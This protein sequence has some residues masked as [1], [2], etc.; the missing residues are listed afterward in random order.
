MFLKVSNLILIDIDF[1]GVVIL[2]NNSIL[3]RFCHKSK[4]INYFSIFDVVIS[5]LYF[6]SAKNLKKDNISATSSSVTF[7]PW[8]VNISLNRI[9]V[10]H[11]LK[12]TNE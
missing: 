5:S 6:F 10:I 1:S 3:P 9:E 7:I 8:S 11:I 4:T 2:E 12:E